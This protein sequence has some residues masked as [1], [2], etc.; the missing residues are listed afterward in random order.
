MNDLQEAQKALEEIV[1]I[2]TAADPVLEPHQVWYEI[3]R[4]LGT[5]KKGLIF[6][7]YRMADD[8]LVVDGPNE[9]L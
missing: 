7:G 4:A 5:A 8:I 9:A 3:G 1:T 6:S 2:L